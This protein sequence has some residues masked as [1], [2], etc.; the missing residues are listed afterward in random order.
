VEVRAERLEGSAPAAGRRRGGRRR[1][2]G[3]GAAGRR[4]LPSPF[5]RR[6]SMILNI[7]LINHEG[8]MCLYRR[9]ASSKP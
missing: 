3:L 5:R 4:G 9:T 6:D 2:L 8:Y 1:R 7:C